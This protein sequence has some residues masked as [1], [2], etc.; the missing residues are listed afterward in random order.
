M[1]QYVIFQPQVRAAAYRCSFSKV[2]WADIA[3]LSDT[4]RYRV[5]IEIMMH[6]GVEATSSLPVMQSLIKV[7][8]ARAKQARARNTA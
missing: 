4:I 1:Q 3:P 8:K 5:L 2:T 6:A 7:R